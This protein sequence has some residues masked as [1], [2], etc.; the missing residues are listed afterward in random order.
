MHPVRTL[1]L[2]L[3]LRFLGGSSHDEG[4]EGSCVCVMMMFVYVIWYRLVANGEWPSGVYKLLRLLD[5]QGHFQLQNGRGHEDTLRKRS[6][7]S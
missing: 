2:P 3:R 4:G 1:G 6:L 5:S 7:G